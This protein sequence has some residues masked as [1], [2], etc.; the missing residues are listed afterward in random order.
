MITHWHTS[1]PVID[2]IQQWIATGCYGFLALLIF[3]LRPKWLTTT[4]SCILFIPAPLICLFLALGL[5]FA[6]ERTGKQPIGDSFYVSRVHWDA[7]AM[8]S[9]GTNLL[10]SY[11]PAYFP[12]F[13]HDVNWIRFDDEKCYSA[14][15]F[16]VIQPDRKHVLARCPWYD[17]QHKDGYHDFLVPL[18]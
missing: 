3:R 15:A 14:R 1:F 13:E 11:Q 7:G 12:F 10:L 5:L 2:E 4:C 16:V 8:G 17:S 9:S 6:G 18:Y